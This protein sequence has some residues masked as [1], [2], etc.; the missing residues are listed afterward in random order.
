MEDILGDD[1]GAVEFIMQKVLF[2]AG[3]SSGEVG[4]KCQVK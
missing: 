2:V 4:G 1:V 3:I